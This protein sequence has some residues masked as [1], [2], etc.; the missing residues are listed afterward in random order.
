M[1]QHWPATPESGLYYNILRFKD[2][3]IMK[4]PGKDHR[5]LLEVA[6]RVVEVA[7]LGSVYLP[8]ARCLLAPRR[9]VDYLH[10]LATTAC[11]PA[12]RDGGAAQRADARG[13]F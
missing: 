13:I 8:S 3:N 12:L 1:V 4:R 7:I 5:G 11:A 9:T 6:D 2:L 10:G